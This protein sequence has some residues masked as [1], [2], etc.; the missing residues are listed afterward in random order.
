MGQILDAEAL[1]SL[2]GSAL[3]ER[4]VLANSFSERVRHLQ[5]FFRQLAL[6]GVQ[7]RTDARITRMASAVATDAWLGSV[8][9]WAREAGLSERTLYNRVQREIG[10][11]PKRLLRL[12]RLQRL[13]R[14]LHP[15]PWAGHPATDPL[16]EFADEAHMHREF[17]L[18]TGLRPRQFTTAKAR[19]GDR[20]IHSVSAA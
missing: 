13:L 6:I 2:T 17:A 16:L 8:S 12:A 20:L 9:R 3:R 11:A 10:C 15:M 4:L 7:G 19:S 18:L 1:P 14:T 5:D